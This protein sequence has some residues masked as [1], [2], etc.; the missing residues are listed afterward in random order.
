MKA[1]LRYFLV[2]LFLIPLSATV[3]QAQT[4]PRPWQQVTAPS[5]SEVAANFKSPPHEYGA[6]AGFTELEQRGPG[7]SQAADSR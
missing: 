1:A 3:S 7:N 2:P 6:I 4:Q 5:T